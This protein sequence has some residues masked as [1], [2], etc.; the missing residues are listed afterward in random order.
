MNAVDDHLAAERQLFSPLLH[1]VRV[2]MVGRDDELARGG[3]IGGA[4]NVNDGRRR[5]SSEPTIKLSRRDRRESSRHPY[6]LEDV[7]GGV[8]SRY[9]KRLRHSQIVVHQWERSDALAGRREDCVEHCG[10]GDADRRLA[11]A[12][13]EASRWHD[14]RL[15]LRHL[16]DAHR[17]VIIEVRLLD[18]TVLDRALLVEQGGEAKDE[19]AS[20]LPLD[21]RRVDRMTW[22]GRAHDAVDFDGTIAADRNLSA[23]RHVAAVTHMLS[24]PTE[25]ALWRRLAPPRRFGDGIEDGEMLGMI[26]HQ[27]APELERVLADRMG[28]LVHE[29]FEIDGVVVD[30]H[31]A[32]E[33]RRDVWVAHGV[34]NQKVRDGVAQRCLAP[35][36]E[37]REGGRVLSVLEASRK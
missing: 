12:T 2:T 33:A 18:A 17:V 34:V 20:D 22:I 36:I 32:P 9:S 7:S 21:L 27:L 6:C 37:A 23:C 30:V 14:D 16:R 4:P 3:K 35:W 29:A 5:G 1:L 31:A 28:K 26:C 8:T 19:R 24:Q 15:D 13:P 25:D 10:C 11:D